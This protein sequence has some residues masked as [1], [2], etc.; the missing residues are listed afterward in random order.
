MRCVF[1]GTGA[2]LGRL[3]GETRVAIWSEDPAEHGFDVSRLFAIDLAMTPNAA[4]MGEISWDAIQ[5]DDLITGPNGSGGTTLGPRWP[6]IQTS[7]A[8]CLE[9]KFIA[10]LPEALRPPCPPKHMH[11][12]PYEHWSLLYWPHIKDPRAGRRYQGHHADIID[13]R[14]GLAR[15]CVYPP[16][17][18]DV[19][20]ARTFKLWMD[21]SDPDQ[22]DAGV[23]QL[24]QIR[25][26]DGPKSGAL[27][28]ISGMLQTDNDI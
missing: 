22:C 24:T 2:Y 4:V 19:P 20:N 1:V 17:T 18:S 15:V 10:T 28:L 21:L 27:F 13:E 9:Q 26:G 7:G 6:E 8:A 25:V 14:G 16:G 23:D 5:V 3:E 11:G 12:R